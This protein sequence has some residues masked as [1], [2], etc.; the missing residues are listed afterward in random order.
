LADLSG[1][2]GVKNSAAEEKFG[3]LVIFIS[4]SICAIE[5]KQSSSLSVGKLKY[6][7]DSPIFID[8]KRR[9]AKLSEI[10]LPC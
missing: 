9:K 10:W 6:F 4:L 3:P 8:N 2:F 5:R 7:L 1:Q